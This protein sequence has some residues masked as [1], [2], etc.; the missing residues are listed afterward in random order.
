MF[1]FRTSK[2]WRRW[3]AGSWWRNLSTEVAWRCA[4]CT[5]CSRSC[6]CCTDC[7]ACSCVAEGRVNEEDEVLVVKGKWDNQG[8]DME[9]TRWLDSFQAHKDDNAILEPSALRVRSALVNKLYCTDVCCEWCTVYSPRRFSGI[10][11]RK[12]KSPPFLR[13]CR[14]PRPP[15]CLPLRSR[16]LQNWS[17]RWRCCLRVSPWLSVVPPYSFAIDTVIEVFSSELL[18]LSLTLLMLWTYRSQRLLRFR[19][20]SILHFQALFECIGKFWSLLKRFLGPSV[21]ERR[22]Q[23]LAFYNRSARVAEKSCRWRAVRS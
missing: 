16:P 10:L 2:M 12:P 15:T 6:S 17:W 7:A 1:D 4:W 18:I 23:C 3:G 14:L 9:H 21:F 20:V 8:W 22:I 19:H 5:G 11:S 13:W